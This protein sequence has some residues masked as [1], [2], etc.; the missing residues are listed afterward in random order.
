MSENEIKTEKP[1]EIVDIVERILDFNNQN[2][3]GQGLKLLTLQKMLSRLPISLDQSEVGNYS[4]KLKNEIR[5]LLYSLYHSKKLFKT[6]Y[7]HLVS[8]I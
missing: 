8:I 2:Q 3:E 6:I 7:K 5:Q 4:E 1:Y